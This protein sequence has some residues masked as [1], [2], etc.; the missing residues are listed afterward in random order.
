MSKYPEIKSHEEYQKAHRTWQERTAEL[1]RNVDNNDFL[2]NRIGSLK[3]M[4]ADLAKLKLDSEG[5]LI[6][7]CADG[8]QVLHANRRSEA[9]KLSN[10]VDRL[11]EQLILAQD[12]ELDVFPWAGD[13]E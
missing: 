9:E 3:A 6:N 10:H 7:D 5:K 12:K 11:H 1:G 8:L 13:E 2:M 4:A